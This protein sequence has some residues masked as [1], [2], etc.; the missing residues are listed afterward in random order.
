[1][2]TMI[3]GVHETLGLRR[4]MW[5]PDFC[6]IPNIVEKNLLEGY[7]A[8]IKACFDYTNARIVELGWHVP[9]LNVGAGFTYILYAADMSRCMLLV[10]NV[11]D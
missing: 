8:H 5:A 3:S 10:A 7:W 2:E 1:M 4:E 6:N 9:F 11:S